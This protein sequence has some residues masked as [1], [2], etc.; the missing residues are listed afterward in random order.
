[1]GKYFFKMFLS[2][3]SFGNA[4]TNSQG[5]YWVPT[6]NWPV[7]LVKGEL[8][9]A[10]ITGKIRYGGYNSSLYGQPMMEA[11]MVTAVMTTKLDPY[12]GAQLSGPLTNAVGYFNGT[13]GTLASPGLGS[14]GHYEVEGVAPG[15]YNLYASAAGYPTALI[16]S[17]VQVLKGQSLHFDGYLNPGPV[18]HGTVFSK[19]SFGSEPWPYYAD[20]GPYSGL[21][22][23]SSSLVSSG[24]PYV[25]GPGRE[26]IKVE[27]YNSP[28][29]N[30]VPS[31]NASLVS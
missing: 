4:P 8:D 3:G 14:D 10:I 30:N 9:P 29:V 20:T 21:G 22:Y 1:A 5:V 11:G 13:M 26:Y 6:E 19:H 31:S 15:I 28:T 18:I 7:L 16:A 24:G 23:A 17:N 2:L 12:T 25:N 27:L